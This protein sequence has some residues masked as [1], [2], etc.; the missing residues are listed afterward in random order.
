MNPQSDPDTRGTGQ[1]ARFLK[2]ATLGIVTRAKAIKSDVSS[3]V[4]AEHKR[5]LADDRKNIPPTVRTKLGQK[6]VEIVAVLAARSKNVEGP[7]EG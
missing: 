4:Q 1:H 5:R 3:L 2:D 7:S 6:D